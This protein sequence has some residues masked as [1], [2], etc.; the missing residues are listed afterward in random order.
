MNL[1]QNKEKQ[2]RVK[3]D[4]VWS[5]RPEQ[6]QHCHNHQVTVGVTCQA[7]GNNN[8]EW[9]SRVYFLSH[10]PIYESFS[11]VVGGRWSPNYAPNPGQTVSRNV[12]KGYRVPYVYMCKA[13]EIAHNK[14]WLSFHEHLKSDLFPSSMV[15][16]YLEVMAA[17]RLRLRLRLRKV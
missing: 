12:T 4:S 10:K 15:D 13:L 7:S 8:L 11:H 6:E 14:K 16:W 3:S 17:L 1:C 2:Q 9:V 5:I